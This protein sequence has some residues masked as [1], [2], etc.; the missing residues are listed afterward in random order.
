M[1]NFQFVRK[2]KINKIGKLLAFSFLTAF[3]ITSC[4]EDAM[5]KVNNNPNNPTDAPAKFLITDL[6]VSTG[7]GVV[8]GDFSLYSSVYMEHETGINNQM[9]RAEV[10]TGNRLSQRPITMSQGTVYS[11]IKN[12]KTYSEMPGRPFEQGNVVTEDYC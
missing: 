2:M 6:G 7:F 8:G 1:L 5:D 10:R 9:Y 12:A 3:S 4:T 11:N